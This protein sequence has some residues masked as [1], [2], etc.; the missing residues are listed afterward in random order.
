MV[1]EPLLK[2]HFFMLNHFVKIL[3]GTTALLFRSIISFNTSLPFRRPFYNYFSPCKYWL[4]KS[5]A[6]TKENR[7]CNGHIARC[8]AQNTAKTLKK[9]I[10]TITLYCLALMWHVILKS[11]EHRNRIVCFLLGNS[12][13]QRPKKM[14]MWWLI[15]FHS[16]VRA[17]FS[18]RN[19]FWEKTTAWN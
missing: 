12:G 2:K 17:I 11:Y 9:L 7:C 10:Y 6:D 14:V 13:N 5:A 3:S 8:I 1:W 15:T 18:P 4:L 19:I 16:F